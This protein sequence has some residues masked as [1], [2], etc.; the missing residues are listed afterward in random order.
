MLEEVLLGLQQLRLTC[1]QKEQQGSREQWHAF[2]SDPQREQG[3][4]IHKWTKLQD[5]NSQGA[6]G[7]AT[8]QEQLGK[9]QKMRTFVWQAIEQQV[10]LTWTRVSTTRGL[11]LRGS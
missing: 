9:H 4:W 8:M 11:D 3:R 5:H 2:L 6:D 7:Y 10:Q 1:L